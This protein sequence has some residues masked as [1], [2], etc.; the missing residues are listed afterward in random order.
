M[1]IIICRETVNITQRGVPENLREKLKC[2][3]KIFSTKQKEGRK[4]D[5]GL[6]GNV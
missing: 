4:G 2:N 1:N 3:A 5:T 6:K